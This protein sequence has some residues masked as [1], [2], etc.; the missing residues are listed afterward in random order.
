MTLDTSKHR[1]FG[2]ELALAIV[3]LLNAATVFSA[4]A[5]KVGAGPD[6]A[7]SLSPRGGAFTAPVTLQ[8]TS[9]LP[10]CTLRYT[11]DGSEPDESSAVY[12]SPLLL[13]NSTLVRAKAFAPGHPTSAGAAEHYTL[14]DEDLLEFSSNLPLVILNSFGTNF[15]RER[16]IEAGV[17]LIDSGNARAKL[18]AT[19]ALSAPCLANVRG[20]ASLRYP[21]NSFTLKIT[22][23]AGDP[24]K[25]SLLGLPA[26]SDW[27]L[28][29]PY[30]DKTL[31]RDVLAYEISAGMGH[32]APRTRF[33]EV[34]VNQTGT[35]L[36]RR[37]YVGVYVLVEKIRRD[38]SRVNMARLKPDD[39][40]EPRVTGGYI[41]K[42]DHIGFGNWGGPGGGDLGGFAGAPGPVT[43][44][45]PGYPTGPGGFP[46]DPKGFQPAYRGS[47]NSSSISSSS[48]SSSRSSRSSRVVVHHLGRPTPVVAGTGREGPMRDEEDDSH[49]AGEEGFKTSHTNEFFFVEPEPDEITGV[50]KAWLKNHLNALEEALYGPDFRDPV[51]GYAGFIDVDS[52]IDYH[53]IVET[54][55]NVDGFR[56]SVFFHKDRGEKIKADPIWDWNLSF[57]NSNGKQ[58]WL[59]ESWLWP[60]LDDKEYSWY[61]R[62]FEDPDFGQRYVDRWTQ[63]R[64]NV[65]ATSVLLSRVDELATLL[66]ESQRRNFEK[67]PILGRPVN[68][69]YFVGSSYAEEVNWMKKFIQTRL[70]WIDRQFP[71]PPKLSLGA[72]RSAAEL[73]SSEGEIFFTLDGTDPRAGGG[74]PSTKSRRYD[75]PFP[76]G[77]GTKLFARV[78]QENRWSGA[79]VARGE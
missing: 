16:K 61:R 38:K 68:P 74:S 8:L 40:S 44:T 62:L 11:L 79:L 70:E 39:S 76:L 66:E 5:E 63:L 51:R 36:S 71:T 43:S 53:L 49:E 73:T 32:W 26:E 18:T 37:D 14:L 78:R 28:Y 41:F 20:R 23:P 3:L 10:Q 7:V 47:R 34:F 6:S 27:V 69:N 29:A 13:T 42:K 60:Q 12:Q 77:K 19:P 30:P 25:V 46:A 55:K 57:G 21:K 24:R 2:L 59:P 67:W 56:F 45:R 72:S 9:S 22:D 1:R 54:T 50:Q 75:K 65:L 4:R 48:S 58:G 35:R 17:Q 33:V 31:M 64:T 15:A 52:F